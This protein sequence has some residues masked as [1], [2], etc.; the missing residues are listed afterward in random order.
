VR[1]LAVASRSLG[2]GLR[3]WVSAP[4]EVA[5]ERLAR[6]TG[7]RVPVSAWEASWIYDQATTRAAG[8]RLDARIDTG[9]PQ[10]PASLVA[11][12]GPMLDA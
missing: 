7:R 8:R 3:V 12:L 11:L 9:R 10:D 6:R 4:K 5:M 1:V 2:L